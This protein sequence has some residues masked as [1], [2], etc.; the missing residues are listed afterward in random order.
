[1]KTRSDLLLPQ[2]HVSRHSFILRVLCALSMLITHIRTCISI[3]PEYMA[4][5][6]RRIYTSQL[7]GARIPRTHI[8]V[9]SDSILWYSPC[10]IPGLH[11]TSFW[12][13]SG[14]IA[15]DSFKLSDISVTS[16]CAC[17]NSPGAYGWHSPR[18]DFYDESPGSIPIIDRPYGR[19]GDAGFWYGSDTGGFIEYELWKFGRDYNIVRYSTVGCL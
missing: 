3:F 8:T 1:M 11:G 6:I 2:K 5:A 7:H 18:C 14:N 16:N 13:V 12:F 15:H 4:R 9:C 17:R 19:N 10:P